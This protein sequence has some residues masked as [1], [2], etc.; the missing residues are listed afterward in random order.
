MG[1]WFDRVQASTAAA[2]LPDREDVTPDFWK[3][4]KLRVAHVRADSESLAVLTSQPDKD[5]ILGASVHM[6]EHSA[7]LP[8]SWSNVRAAAVS[9]DMVSERFQQC[10]YLAARSLCIV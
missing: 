6:L 3:W 7:H 10:L 2:F 5:V 1:S 9:T 4:W 8:H